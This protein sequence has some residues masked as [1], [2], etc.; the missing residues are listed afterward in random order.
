M[1]IKNKVTLYY[2]TF[3]IG[4][5]AL[6]AFLPGAW[7]ALL[8]AILLFYVSC[9]LVPRVFDLVENPLPDGSSTWELVKLGFLPY[10]LIWLV[11]W[12]MVYTLTV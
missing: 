4:V 8:V 6:S 10:F 7:E 1:K 12:I 9:R 5:G 2:T 3:G 11:F